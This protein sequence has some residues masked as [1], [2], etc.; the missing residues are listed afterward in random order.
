LSPDEPAAADEIWLPG[1]AA[2]PPP[3]V[4]PPPAAEPS[5]PAAEP[6]P[7][8]ADFT[9]FSDQTGRPGGRVS[10]GHTLQAG[11]PYHLEVAVRVAPTGIPADQPERRAIREPQQ[12]APLTL[13][14]TL[15][16]DGFEIEEPVQTLTLPPAGDSTRN[17]LFVVRPLQ[18][19]AHANALAQIRVRLYYQFNLLEVAV[20]SAEVVGK[21]DDA[22]QS[23][24][25]LAQPIEF[26]QER[27]EREYLDLDHVLPRAMHVDVTRHGE[28][29]LFH[30]A[31]YND[32]EDR[33]VFSA[34][35]RLTAAELE[36]D[37]VTIRNLWYDIAMSPT[38]T[39]QL[40]GDPD[41]FRADVRRLAKAGRDL[42]AT[43]FRREAGGA[44]FQVGQWLQEHPLQRDAIVQI[45]LSPDAGDFVFPWALIYDRQVPRK[46]YELPDLEGFWG[47]RYCV[48]QQLPMVKGADDPVHLD[49]EL[50]LGFMLWEQFRNVAEQKK[51]M[52]RLAEAAG[53]RLQ[54]STP[55]ITDADAC[56]ELLANCDAHLLYFYTHGYTRHRQAD[57]G[58]GPNLDRFRQ[59]YQQLAPDSPLRET[60]RLLYESIEQGQFEPDRSWIELTYGK[61][62]LDEL[63]DSIDRL[64]SGPFVML[65]MC[66]SAQVTPSLS[67]SFIHFFLD[68]GA[69]A[70]MG[71][72]CPMTVEFAHPFAERFL[73]D[74]LGGTPVGS[75]LLN[76][77]RHF[78][79]KKNPLGLAYTLFG[80]ATVAFEP[81]RLVGTRGDS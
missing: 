25:G 48:E 10:K 78:L 13:M 12:A 77:R 14:V 47:V 7:R 4:E 42:W 57:I 30:F 52:Q 79:E 8:Y 11:Q 70:V 24:L 64:P 69:R 33:L 21:F 23:Q 61:L 54:I 40:E 74:V 18:E 35:A 44:L 17:A 67:D 38:F 43:L 28:H 55:P 60:Y 36:D 72:E 65:N 45:S 31:F 9:F 16:G 63:Y 6:P 49:Q 15:E 46:D 68:R 37:L 76:A 51:L 73:E 32:V 75:A 53:G 22:S 62:Y 50:I 80:R 66:E 56:Y 19:S 3:A 39:R 5:P 59:H 34:P 1:E 20:I 58:V 26:R 71:T 2:E 27:L 41:E 81:P 29:Y